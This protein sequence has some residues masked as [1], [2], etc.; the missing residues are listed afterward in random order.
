LTIIIAMLCLCTCKSDDLRVT[1]NRQQLDIWF[2][3]LVVR[4][5]SE[6]KDLA[7]FTT[8]VTVKLP[9][10]WPQ[11]RDLVSAVVL[12]FTLSLTKFYCYVISFLPD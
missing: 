8:N 3:Q 9:T 10:F 5:F 6:H 11:S 4:E 12:N 1:W 7:A 2:V